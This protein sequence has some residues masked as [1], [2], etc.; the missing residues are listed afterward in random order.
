MWDY[1]WQ[2]RHGERAGR[3]ACSWPRITSGA[4][5]R[6]PEPPDRAPSVGRGH[7][8]VR[9][10]PTAGVTAAASMTARDGLGRRARDGLGRLASRATR[11]VLT[12]VQWF[13]EPLDWLCRAPRQLSRAIA[14]RHPRPFHPFGWAAR[15]RRNPRSSGCRS[16]PCFSR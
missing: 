6:V 1:N 8:G 13:I 3:S 5:G 16:F 10:R 15:D 14:A 4:G 11:R 9:G 12:S 2:A 7:D